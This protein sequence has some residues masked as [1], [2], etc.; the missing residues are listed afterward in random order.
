MV[1]T[2]KYRLRSSAFTRP[3]EEVSIPPKRVV[4]LSVEGSNTEIDYFRHLNSRLDNSLIHI[5]LLRH[6]CSDGYSDPEQ[7]I[8]L[9]NEYIH[10]RQGELIPE[11]SMKSLVEKHSMDILQQYLKN[12]QEV[13]AEQRKNIREDLLIAGIDLDYR[14]YLQQYTND[15]DVFA[16]VIDRDGGSHSRELMEKCVQMCRANNYDC[17]ISNPCFEFWLLLHLCDVA[18]EYTEEELEEFR[19]NAKVSNKHTKTSREVNRRAHHSKHIS[20]NKFD[21][22]YGPNI[23]TAIIRAQSFANDTPELFDHLGTS[24]PKLFDA[25]GYVPN[26]EE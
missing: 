9:L 25:L 19:C 11:D 24:V 8:E 20:P 5:E 16:I 22:Y 4:F 15:N 12:S 6:R 2:S 23:Q 21:S 7:V 1:A 13:T 26:T 3:D 10:V 14:R 18:Q 17:Y